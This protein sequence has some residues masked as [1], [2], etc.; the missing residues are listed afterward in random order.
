MTDAMT[1][2][3]PAVRSSARRPGRRGERFDGTLMPP[4]YRP[5]RPSPLGAQPE[6]TP[7]I[8]W[9]AAGI[10][11]V[12]GTALAGCSSGTG[13]PSA[14]P[15]SSVVNRHSTPIP[16]DTNGLRKLDRE[17]QTATGVHADPT[18]S[19]KK[20]RQWFPGDVGTYQVGRGIPPGMYR[21]VA[22]ASGRC[23]WARLNG[24][25]SPTHMVIAHGLTAGPV[26]VTIKAGDKFFQTSGCASWHR[27]GGASRPSG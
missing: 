9:C 19:S 14:P 25:S 22:S 27:V 1:N 20:R 24:S 17:T 26:T 16:R 4:L 23:A 2:R 11:V 3:G 5:R 18:S 21:S 8:R 7:M 6:G 15:S 12:L 10:V 13:G